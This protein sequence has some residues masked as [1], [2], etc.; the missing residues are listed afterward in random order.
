M[1]AVTFQQNNEVRLFDAQSRSLTRVYKNPDAGLDGPHGLLVTDNHIIVGNVH[2]MD[3]PSQLAVYE[4]NAPST[5]PVSIYETPFKHLREAHSL[6]IHDDTLVVSYC[7]KE[8]KTGAIVSYRFDDATGK[9]TDVIDKQESCFKGYG[10]AKGVTFNA[11]G[12]KVLVSFNSE[13]KKTT[14]EKRS[15][16]YSHAKKAW[17]SGGVSDLAKE[18]LRKISRKVIQQRHYPVL[19]NGIMIF[20]INKNGEF[21]RHPVKLILRKEFCRL[22]NINCVDNIC[23]VT[24]LVNQ[25]VY[26][27]DISVDESLEE[28]IQIIHVKNALPHGAKISPD[29][30]TIVLANF[31]LEK[32]EDTIHWNLWRT[33]R[34]DKIA[35][36]DLLET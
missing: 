4:I 9:I 23:V 14:R 33:P 22:E 32:T 11:D 2:K 34:E 12:T 27:Y 35:I 28:P 29:K 13:K 19:E 15:I 20:S 1:F 10:D 17:N 5:G 21:S 31:G 25:R 24:D 18:V 7:E 3:K 6:A 36:Y 26:L 8:D 16:N 30:K